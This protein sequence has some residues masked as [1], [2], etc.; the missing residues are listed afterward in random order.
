MISVGER[1]SVMVEGQIRNWLTRVGTKKDIAWFDA[2]TKLEPSEET[3]FDLPDEMMTEVGLLFPE[4]A[5]DLRRLPGRIEDALLQ[6]KNNKGGYFS[7]DP[8]KPLPMWSQWAE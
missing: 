3:A 6:S 7:G 5:E 4:L 1:V 2:I 8:Q